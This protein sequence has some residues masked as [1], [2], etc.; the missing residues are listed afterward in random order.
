MT[1]DYDTARRFID[2][3][4]KETP[5]P[6][7]VT[8]PPKKGWRRTVVCRRCGF[9][10]SEAVY[11]YCANCGHRIADYIYAGGVGWPDHATAEAAFQKLME[12]ENSRKDL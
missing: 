4:S 2:A 3:L 9:G 7:K 10:I 8:D 11:K 1:Y 12:T 6:P 5:L